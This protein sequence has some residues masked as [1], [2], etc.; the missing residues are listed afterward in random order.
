M[1]KLKI[2]KKGQFT[3]I[4]ALLVAVVLIAAVMTTYSAI[5]YSTVEDNPQVLSAV[6]EINLAL[7][8]VVGF[9]VGYYGSVLQVTGNTSYARLLASNYLQS[10]LENIGD[11]RPEWSASFN[12]TTLNLR[13]DWFSNASFSS[14]NLSVTYDLA[15]IG[16]YNMTYFASSRLD[17]EIL[18]SS[19]TQ[20]VVS[21]NKDGTEPL[22]N[23]AKQNLRF[24][25]YLDET[26]T[27]E[28]VSPTTDPI[29]YANGTYIIDFP[30]GVDPDSYLIKIEDTRGII[31]VA[32]SFSSY[33]AAI[34]QNSTY[35][36]ADYVDLD[37]SD[38]DSSSDIGSQSNFTAQQS[39][40]DS[41]YDTLTETNTGGGAL[42]ITLI[43]SESFEGSWVPSGWYESS[44]WNK[45]SDEVKDGGYSADF[46]GWDTGRSG[47]L[48]TPS[49]DCSDASKIF[50]DFWFYDAG[51]E[52]DEFRLYYWDGH[53]WDQI[54]QLGAYTE[55]Q[56]VH[57]QHEIDES[58]YLIGDFQI[59]FRADDIEG[60][61]HA[62]VDLVTVTK[63]VDSTSFQLDIEE[64]F[65]NVNYTDPQQALC[66]KAGSLGS[67][68]LVVD[69]WT[70]SNW[71]TLTTLTGLVNGWKNVSVSSYLTSATLTIRFRGSSDGLDSIQD[72]WEIDAVLLG[73]Q[74]DLSMILSQEDSTIVVEWLQNGTMRFLGE[75]LD[76]S[77]EAKAI[78]P[79]SV[80]SLHLNQ[81][82]NGVEQ[83]V[84]FQV[85]DWASG[86]KIPLGLTSNSTVFGS[87]QMVVFLLDSGV[88][89]FKLWWDGS[90]EAIQTPLAYTNQYFTGDDPD[91]DE[92]SNGI[93]HLDIG[94]FSVTSTVIGTYTSSTA[95]FMRI[96]NEDS[97]YGAGAAYVIY[98]GV[99][100]DII[101]QEAEWSSGASNCPNVYANIVITLPANVTYYNYQLRLMF[102]DSA[103]SRTITD[104]CPISLT[105]SVSSITVQTE[106]GT[107]NGYPIVAEGS[108]TFYDY[109]GSCLAHHWSQMISS[110]TRGAGIMFTDTANVKLYRFD[111][112][113][114]TTV[115]ALKTSTSSKTI[116][117]LPVGLNSV[118]NFYDA[119]DVTWKGA[120]VTF[121]DTMPIYK[122]DG[123]TPTGLWILAE[124]LPTITVTS[125]S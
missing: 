122:L 42:N 24:Y 112:V 89:E 103:Q 20:A 106:N 14:G 63:E 51:C 39:A 32:S 22:I 46:D 87:S 104:L 40:P 109:S 111:S 96:N 23:L 67:E 90:D 84:P 25:H 93:I 8:Q 17:V 101:Q 74:P 73:P 81:T 100:R 102:I 1:K 55:Y 41:T 21:V 107:S 91:D 4:A 71:A 38:V 45:E 65:T 117:L 60:G 26:S 37:T 30:A 59:R 125:E 69:V 54:V 2:N 118:N 49:M 48:Y 61:E 58:Q 27:W 31:V 9:T 121:D 57:W 3:I 97:V 33:V 123:S 98:N 18:G 119:L 113:A 36:D 72:S 52:N 83:E 11:I 16:L 44:N 12:V 95:T 78:P 82:I 105:T 85:E 79:I 88:S 94:S 76:M 7:K 15:G 86:Y 75:N 108:G 5:R 29:V 114:G 116:E 124:Y 66:I 34:I 47:S 28:L 70:G 13:T 53:D 77:T 99:V 10:G 19:E 62:Y 120:V 92:L 80:K 115:G 56:W 68:D 64:Q 6:D 43:N 35:T 110:G 50:V